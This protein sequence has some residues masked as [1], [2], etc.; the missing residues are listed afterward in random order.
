MDNAAIRRGQRGNTPASVRRGN[1]TSTSSFCSAKAK[2]V[3]PSRSTCTQ[4]S[5]QG[6]ALAGTDPGFG[7]ITLDAFK[8]G[9]LV[10]VAVELLTDASA[11]VKGA[12]RSHPER[13]RT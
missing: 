8:H 4:V 5:G 12:I 7:K 11:D 10:R 3:L 9:Q 6:T 13:R 2:Q 1:R